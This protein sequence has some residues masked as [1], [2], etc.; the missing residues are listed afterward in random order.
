MEDASDPLGRGKRKRTTS[1]TVTQQQQQQSSKQSQQIPLLPKLLPAVGSPSSTQQPDSPANSTPTADRKTRQGTG[2]AIHRRSQSTSASDAQKP[3]PG[4][5]KLKLRLGTLPEQGAQTISTPSKPLT[6]AQLKVQRRQQALATAAAKAA[7]TGSST[8]MQP[9][10]QNPVPMTKRQRTQSMSAFP[11]NNTAT[12]P[13]DN[14]H[15]YHNNTHSTSN[16]H[17][18]S[19]PGSGTV[20]PLDMHNLTSSPSSPYRMPQHFPHPLDLLTSR[21]VPEN[22]LFGAS[23]P[24]STHVA[25]PFSRRGSP[26]ANLIASAAM[27]KHRSAS[28]SINDTSGAPSAL[29]YD[30]YDEH[31]EAAYDGWGAGSR[32]LTDSAILAAQHEL[33]VALSGAA[34]GGDVPDNFDFH[35]AMLKDDSFDFE[36]DYSLD[37]LEDSTRQRSA[38]SEHFPDHVADV[39]TVS[40]DSKKP[41]SPTRR[42]SSTLD[43]KSLSDDVDGIFEGLNAPSS[44]AG[45]AAGEPN[46]D[47]AAQEAE[48]EHLLKG[49]DDGLDDEALQAALNTTLCPAANG[50]PSRL[51]RESFVRVPRGVL[52]A[53][54]HPAETIACTVRRI[55]S[56]T[57]LVFPRLAQ[58]NKGPQS[59]LLRPNP[60][61]RSNSRDI[62]N[63]PVPLAELPSLALQSS[64]SNPILLYASANEENTMEE[65][66]SESRSET[67]SILTPLIKAEEDSE[68]LGDLD[69]QDSTA[70]TSRSLSRSLSSMSSEETSSADTFNAEAMVYTR[71][72]SELLDMEHDLEQTASRSQSSSRATSL[73]PR[74]SFSP[75]NIGPNADWA[76]TP[77]SEEE[78]IDEEEKNLDRAA[79]LGPESVGMDDLDDAWPGSRSYTSSEGTLL[80]GHD[81]SCDSTATDRTERDAGSTAKVPDTDVFE[82]VLPLAP[83]PQTTAA[84][85]FPASHSVTA[86][87]TTTPT[88]PV[89]A[90]ETVDVP[91]DIDVENSNETSAAAMFIADDAPIPIAP[92]STSSSSSALTDLGDDSKRSSP[93]ESSPAKSPSAIKETPSASPIANNPTGST[94]YSGPVSQQDSPI[95]PNLTTPPPGDAST[96][97]QVPAAATQS[98][99]FYPETPFQPDITILL[100]DTKILFYST[101]VMIDGQHRPLLRRVDNDAVDAEPLLL[102]L[103]G[104]T[105][106]DVERLDALRKIKELGNTW[107]SLEFARELLSKFGGVKPVV[108][109]CPV[110]VP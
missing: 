103:Q 85:S 37:N 17:N 33:A 46:Q 41:G 62:L 72:G 22:H 7:A 5:R 90:A 8:Q 40:E 12:F 64:S 94:Q 95:F 78:H 107:V 105:D 48:V 108:S 25:G 13:F 75:Q 39:S 14:L 54:E 42:G 2:N 83:L 34:E 74:D 91:M 65:P 73:S 16:L 80:P 24:T 67:S 47:A 60:I 70:P 76:L 68:E 21:S 26:I 98:F 63:T 6:K 27:H 87:A 9:N 55:N 99:L 52:A 51:L 1:A 10:G 35:E 69:L 50:K 43:L 61:S 66:D 4:L 11:A 106:L 23:T 109:P 96:P 32:S 45:T 101:L 58:N 56:A 44:T 84:T 100:T 30:E 57:N 104:S 20:F 28:L 86:P 82:P 18:T 81:E 89:E 97:A 102:S 88:S 19:I 31:A 38:T 79:L 53:E 77:P 71:S 29:E 15:L 93:A 3:L 36:F 110:T 92:S 59:P 49:E